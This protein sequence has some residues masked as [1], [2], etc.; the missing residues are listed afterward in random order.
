M[1]ICRRK[2]YYLAVLVALFFGAEFLNAQWLCQTGGI[3]SY[4]NPSTIRFINSSSGWFG[5]GGL[6][7]KTTNAGINWTNV[8]NTGQRIHS[9]FGCISNNDNR[10]GCRKQDVIHFERRTDVDCPAAGGDRRYKFDIL[11]TFRQCVGCRK[12]RFRITF[13]LRK[14]RDSDKP[15]RSTR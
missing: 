3:T 11:C 14:H 5:G 10:L 12:L 15:N 1:K 9:P 6:L 2:V 4:Y 13:K 7:Y 8:L